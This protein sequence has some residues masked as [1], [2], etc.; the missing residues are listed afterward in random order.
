[1]SAA[2]TVLPAGLP[3]PAPLADGL[4]RPY[5][6]ALLRHPATRGLFLYYKNHMQIKY[7]I[8]M[9]LFTV[10]RLVRGTDAHGDPEFTLEVK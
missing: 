6:D 7:R 2:D 10:F 9:A 5:W 3:A 1:M 4:D 8:W